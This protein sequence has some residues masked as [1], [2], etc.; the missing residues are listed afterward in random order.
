MTISS[1]RILALFPREI[2]IYNWIILKKFYHY[3]QLQ[4]ER[5]LGENSYFF[6]TFDIFQIVHDFSMNFQKHKS[7]HDFPWFSMTFPDFPWPW[8]PL[9]LGPSTPAANRSWENFSQ[10]T[11]HRGQHL[12]VQVFQMLNLAASGPLAI[13][14]RSASWAPNLW[15]R[16]QSLVWPC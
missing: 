3:L 14:Q 6:M 13:A 5:K 7:F 1:P 11:T 12:L 15:T 2:H 4:F 9:L 10:N 8:K 16:V